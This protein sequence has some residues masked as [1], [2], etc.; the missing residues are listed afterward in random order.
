MRRLTSSEVAVIDGLTMMGLATGWEWM[1]ALDAGTQAQVAFRTDERT[2]GTN[3]DTAMKTHWAGGGHLVIHHNH[4]SGES[5]SHPDWNCLLD[6]DQPMD[7]I[8]ACTLDGT[9]Y[10]GAL[11]DD[12]TARQALARYGFA[13][14]SA[15]TAIFDSLA[16]QTLGF[17]TAVAATFGKHAVSL[18]LG[19]RGFAYDIAPGPVMQR[20]LAHVSGPIAAGTA[21]AL[22]KL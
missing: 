14:P 12:A 11:V 9:V 10:Y 13:H 22:A 1:A 6:P 8:F 18:A 21:A 5:L 4:P 19:Q 17:R 2:D 7:E 3:S 15:E 20:A 16:G